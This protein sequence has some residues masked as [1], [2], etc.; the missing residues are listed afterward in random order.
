[1]KIQY[2]F[3]GVLALAVI[4]FVYRIVRYKGFKA[5]LFGARILSTVGEVPTRERGL[6]LSCLSMRVHVLEE[7]GGRGTAVGLEVVS[8][9][10]ARPYILTMIL[11]CEQARDLE[12]LL[13]R[14]LQYAAQ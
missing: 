5:A 7:K 6:G 13:S 9:G 14:A 4:A 8:T 3:L 10:A 12:K 2:V 1:M 11:G